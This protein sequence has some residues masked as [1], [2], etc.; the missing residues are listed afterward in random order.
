MKLYFLQKEYKYFEVSVIG[1]LNF[2]LL[3]YN[4]SSAEEFINLMFSYY[5]H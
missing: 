4:Y 3:Q 2:D 5:F 1:D